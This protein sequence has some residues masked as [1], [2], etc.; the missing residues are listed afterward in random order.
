MIIQWRLKYLA[1]CAEV[2][3]KLELQFDCN[4]FTLKN[5]HL[6]SNSYMYNFWMQPNMQ[7]NL[8]NMWSQSCSASIVNLDKNLLQLQIYQIFPRGLTFW[9]AVYKPAGD[10]YEA[11]TAW[12]ICEWTYRLAMCEVRLFLRRIWHSV[13]APSL[14]RHRFQFDHLRWR[15]IFPLQ[16]TRS[17]SA[18][19]EP[20]KNPGYVAWVQVNSS[21]SWTSHTCA[22]CRRA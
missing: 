5:V 22:F 12:H 18:Y 4:L 8:Q 11:S 16:H 1:R 10:A 15:V 6:S 3:L 13:S 19:T 2:I 17:Q 7:W 21:P 9:C 14:T 20:D